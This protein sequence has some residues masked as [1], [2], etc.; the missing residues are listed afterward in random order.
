MV[1]QQG[2]HQ[3]NQQTSTTIMEYNARRLRVTN[4]LREEKR[5]NSLKKRITTTKPL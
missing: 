2:K 4:A 3:N 5:S 1:L